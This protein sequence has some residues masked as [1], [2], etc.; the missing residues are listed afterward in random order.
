MREDLGRTALIASEKRVALLL[1]RETRRW[2]EGSV[3][4]NENRSESSRIEA[5]WVGKNR[6]KSYQLAT[7]YNA[8]ESRWISCFSIPIASTYATSTPFLSA[9]KLHE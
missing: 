1:S 3:A 7:G 4:E 2:T 8:S 6:V 9:D 5:V